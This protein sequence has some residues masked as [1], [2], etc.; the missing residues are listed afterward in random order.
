M[1]VESPQAEP[2]LF[3]CF[4][5]P[6]SYHGE[7]GEGRDL[8]LDLL[9]GYCLFAMTIDHVEG[10]SSWLYRISA[11]HAIQ[12]VTAAEI[13]VFISGTVTGLVYQSVIATDGFRDATIRLFSRIGKLYAVVLGLALFYLVLGYLVPGSFGDYR[14][15]D[16][17]DTLVGALTLRYDPSGLFAMYILFLAS[18]P[19]LLFA[20]EEGKTWH[21]LGASVLVWL[22]NLAYP[23]YFETPLPLYFQFGS[24]QLIF[25][26]GLVAGYHRARLAALA[27]RWRSAAFAY[28]AL[29]AVLAM[30]LLRLNGAIQAGE[31]D[32]ALPGLSGPVPETVYEEGGLVYVI[33]DN[34]RL[35]PPRLFTALVYVQVFLLLVHFFYRL[36]SAT[37][38]RLLIPLGQASLYVYTMHLVVVYVLLPLVPGFY[39]IP[40]PFYGFAL[41]GVV[42]LLWAMVR[43]RFLFFLIP[44]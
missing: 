22:G 36:L 9:R 23:H 28:V 8:R 42:L 11:A 40:G 15:E 27:G 18:S 13:F 29:V 2:R 7:V 38:G 34:V 41:L 19:L 24:W 16:P 4:A 17:V 1:A 30:V 6:W 39:E 12:L 35:P 20:L 33:Y 10:P 32:G 43:T 21:L 14:S 3:R 31:F 26:L 5:W 44:R 25:V 37:L